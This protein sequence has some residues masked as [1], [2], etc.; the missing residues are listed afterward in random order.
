MNAEIFDFRGKVSERFQAFRAMNPQP[1][2]ADL[3][4]FFERAELAEMSAWLFELV[5][6]SEKVTVDDYEL[7]IA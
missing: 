4:D 5:F 6:E 2:R 1:T 3:L 7:A